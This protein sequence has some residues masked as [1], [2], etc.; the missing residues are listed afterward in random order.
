[1]AK[2]DGSVSTFLLVHNAIGMAVIDALG[3]EE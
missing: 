1:M 2:L 3:D